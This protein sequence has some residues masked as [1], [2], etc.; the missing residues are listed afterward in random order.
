MASHNK[1]SKKS[2]KKNTKKPTKKTGK[3][4]PSKKTEKEPI[5]VVLFFAHWCG[6][7]Q[8]MYPEWE[9]L[10]KEYE[11]NDDFILK[12]I[13]HGNIELEKPLLEKEYGMSP[14][15]VQGFPTL[16]K[17]RPHQQ[18]EYYEGGERTKENFIT[19]LHGKEERE[20]R[21][22]VDMM[23]FYYGG[24]KIPLIGK[25][26]LY[27][28]NKTTKSKSKASKGKTAKKLTPIMVSKK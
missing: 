14:I 5:V 10:R 25:V 12:E 15:Q 9:K 2:L 8:A 1:S 13:E 21:M 18:V 19:W 4:A 26:K 6:H 11:N 3:K 20:E 17:F 23:K 16:A 24:Y 28:K 22:P 27:S 7:C